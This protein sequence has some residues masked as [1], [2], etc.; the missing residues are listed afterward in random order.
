AFDAGA[1]PEVGRTR[2]DE[3]VAIGGHVEV[4]IAVDAQLTFRDAPVAFLVD[5][6]NEIPE[7]VENNNVASSLLG[8]RVRPSF[9]NQG[10]VYEYWRWSGLAA[11][12]QINSLNQTPAVAQLTDDNGDGVVNEYDTPD[13][14]FV[15]GMRNQSAPSQTALVALDGKTGRELWSRTDFRLAHFS[16]PAVGDLDND[17]VAEIVVVTGYRTELIAF[18]NDG[19]LKWRRALNGP[20]V[21]VPLIPPPP[22]VYDAPI[23]VNLEGDNEAEVVLGR[24]AYRGLNGDKLWEGEFDAGSD[25]GKPRNAPLA[26]ASGVASIAADVDLDGRMEVIAGRT[27]YDFEGRTI[28][29]LDDDD[30]YFPGY[31]AVNTP[32]AESGYVAVGNFDLDD[33][34]EIVLV[35]GRKITLVEHTGTRTWTTE[36]PDGLEMGAPAIADI[37]NDG[38]PE[39]IVSSRGDAGTAPTDREGRLTVFESDGTV[40]KTF[41]I[42]DRNGMTSATVFDLQN[43]GI[44]E[45]MHADQFNFRIFDAQTLVPLY[46]TA[47]SSRTVYENP[48]V[49]D[50]DG[51]KQAEIIITGYDDDLTLPTPGIRVFKARNGAWADA[52]SVWGSHAFHVDEI[53]EDSTLPLLETPS[54]LT[55]NTYRVQRSPQ[56]D[57]LGMPDFTVGDLRL[58][59]Q[60]PGRNPVV[61]VR[62]GNAGPVD[63]H[64]PPWIGVYRGDPAAGG[65]LL[66]ET[67]LDTLR[68]A[69]FQIVNLGEVTIAGSGDLYAV[70]DQRARATE[71]RETNNQ[72][73]VPFAATNG[74]GDLQLST[75]R[76]S[77]RPGD[78]VTLVATVANQG[79]I[80]ADY[81]VTWQIRDAQ[82]REA[83]ALADLAFGA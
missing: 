44:M 59:D 56:P 60:G 13:L 79:A 76:I 78:V 14:V 48:V 64:E 62:V 1:E 6:E 2:V 34:A 33:Y 51:D 39:I 21:P 65:V 66:K 73:H 11:N 57:P 3:D 81:T 32:L 4:G 50:V 8:C 37:D 35:I 23:I 9:V 19:T 12:P 41:D 55:H 54:W 45:L 63:A 58:V 47:N 80:P 17:G 31:D 15:A 43:D 18:E 24:A 74:R 5:A 30:L 75:D 22:F 7:Q 29:H 82:G 16:S 67:R 10:N 68:A 71:C 26:K 70:V 49:A 36:S 61:Q 20:G 53:N 52:G 72:R 83:A 28:W 38:L 69:R 46:E 25:G 40:K 42:D 27:M 77:Y